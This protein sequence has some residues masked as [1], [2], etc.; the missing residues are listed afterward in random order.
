MMSTSDEAD[1]SGQAGTGADSSGEASA[2]GTVTQNTQEEE[3]MDSR[4]FTDI[5]SSSRP[6]DAL[7]GTW[8][9]AGNVLK[10]KSLFIGRSVSMLIYIF[11][12]QLIL[13]RCL[14]RCCG[15]AFSSSQGCHGRRKGRR[16]SR[17]CKRRLDGIGRR[18]NR[19]DSHGC[20]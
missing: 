17:R 20:W 10:G 19:G 12:M 6:K 11:V 16:C 1:T 3:E 15:D 5:F 7:D 9:G 4:V 18:Y 8:K 13:H 2:G 14:G